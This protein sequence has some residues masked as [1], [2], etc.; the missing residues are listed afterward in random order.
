[1]SSFEIVLLLIG[2][3]LASSVF[4]QVLPRVSLPLVQIALGAAVG[5]LVTADPTQVFRDP[6]LFLVLFIAPL[7]FEES[8]HADKQALLAAW[9]PVASL[10]IGLVIATTLACGLA[11][12]LASPAIPLAAA[13]ALGA[14]L[15]PTDAAAVAAMG[16]DVTLT[17][18]QK[19]LLSGEALFNDASGVVCFEFAVAAAAT[20][21][22]S[23]THAAVTFAAD[24]F[25]GIIVGLALGALITLV[26]AKV[27][28]LGL[29]TPTE[30]V[31][32][33]VLTPFVT[34]LA[35]EELG[36]S[37]ILA[38]VAAGLLMRFSPRGLTV[39]ASRHAL[40][41][42]SVWELLT[43][44]INGTLFVLLG[45]KLPSTLGPVWRVSHG[46]DA[47]WICSLVL[48]ATAIVVGIRLAWVLVL[49]KIHRGRHADEYA[50]TG[51]AALVRSA[52]VTCLSGPKGA[53]TLSIML[54]LP[55]LTADGSAFPQRS[56]LIFVASGVIVLTLLL[57]NFI[58]PA[59]APAE[60]TTEADAALARAK[61]RVL[62]S[63]IDELARRAT[64]ETRAATRLALRTYRDRLDGVLQVETSPDAMRDLRV[65]V[66]DLQIAF[67]RAR[68]ERGENSREV[69]QR[70]MAA[71][72]QLRGA[73][74]LHRGASGGRARRYAHLARVG[75]ALHGRSDEAECRELAEL[76]RA[77]EQ[78][79]IDAL[80]AM[81]GELDNEQARAARRLA[82]E[83]RAH[84]AMTFSD[85][86]AAQ[87]R[88]RIREQARDIEAV[89]LSLEL[90]Q[91]RRLHDAGE[92]STHAAREL[93]EEIY[94]LQ[95]GL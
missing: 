8:R 52:L 83:H 58:V 26:V 38:V 35:A 44:A 28:D 42:E 86:N 74:G 70:Y 43:F 57:A 67:V 2:C 48:L 93:R 94:L 55:Y 75:R 4:S 92:L 5:C 54:T 11:L 13:F 18:R 62:R 84:L 6:E 60:D 71:L 61:A 1:M 72:E 32:F 87:A 36:V 12:H 69:A 89:G 23:A 90:E 80:A 64:P 78:H 47:A 14:A 3:L 15:G 79:A 77:T 81:A 29:E 17:R 46:A 59:L 76:H 68:A 31:L 41:S 88:A 19:S 33:E 49:E 10:A 21:E 30:H 16:A 34:F 95:M 63:V 7:L 91:I 9:A 50:G 85:G 65:R 66:L 37:G 22:F 82:G 56:L 20:G 39:E 73:Y 27:R 25:G 45:M 53:V 24:F 40:A 51:T